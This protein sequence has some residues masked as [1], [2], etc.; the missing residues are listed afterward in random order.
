MSLQFTAVLFHIP[1]GFFSKIFSAAGVLYNRS[2]EDS[3]Y[4]FVEYVSLNHINFRLF[5]SVRKGTNMS[6]PMKGWVRE[7]MEIGKASGVGW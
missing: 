5:R 7:H 1:Y 3:S 6:H 2:L 4:Y